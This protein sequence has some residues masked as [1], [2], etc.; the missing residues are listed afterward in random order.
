[1]SKKFII[2]FLLIVFAWILGLAYFNYTINSYK[3]DTTTKTDAIIVLTGGRNRISEAVNLLNKGL[4]EKLF[5]SGVQKDISLEEIQKAGVGTNTKGEIAL[6]DNSINT[7]ENAI[8]SSKWI[9]ENHVK[10]I[11]LVTSNYHIPRSVSEFSVRNPKTKIIINPVYSEYVS[12]DVWKNSGSFW[13]IFS[14]YNKYLYAFV[15]NYLE[16]PL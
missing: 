9:K 3:V 8:E 7:V 1:M 11:R 13:L 10:S 16:K 2:I 6:E 4:A 15:R 5:I 12:K 14:E